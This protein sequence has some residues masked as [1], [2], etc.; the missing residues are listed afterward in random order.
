MT[1]ETKL[2]IGG[3]QSGRTLELIKHSA[4]TGNTIVCCNVAQRRYMIETA[5]HLN[6]SIPEPIV[7][8]G[9]TIHNDGVQI[10]IRESKGILIDDIDY[11]LDSLFGGKYAGAVINSEFVKDITMLPGGVSESRAMKSSNKG[12]E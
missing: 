10:Q 12:G 6:L 5:A 8:N 11:L 3:R 2:I 7:M 1:S 4:K 9:N